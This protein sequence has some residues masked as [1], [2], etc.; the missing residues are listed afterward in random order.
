MQFNLSRLK[1]LGDVGTDEGRQWLLE[2]VDAY[3]V[4]TRVRSAQVAAALERADHPLVRALAHQQKGVSA[5]LG[6][7]GMAGHFQAIEERPDDGSTVRGHLTAILT[8]L[9]RLRGEIDRLTAPAISK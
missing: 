5:M 4:D 1:L 2:V 6:A 3:V 7:E 9:D 8:G